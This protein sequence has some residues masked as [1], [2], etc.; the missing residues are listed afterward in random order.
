MF[1]TQTHRIQHD[2]SESGRWSPTGALFLLVKTHPIFSPAPQK[3]SGLVGPHDGQISHA[4]L[5]DISFLEDA[6]GSEGW[7]YEQDGAVLS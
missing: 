2:Q 3:P 1:T 4:D 5:L 6:P 7:F